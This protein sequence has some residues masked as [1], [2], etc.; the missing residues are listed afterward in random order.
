MQL[1]SL[2][3]LVFL[4]F[5]SRYNL[6][7]IHQVLSTTKEGD[8]L[9]AWLPL[10]GESDYREEVME[11]CW[12]Q[13]R[14]SI[15][16][17]EEN[18]VQAI[19]FYSDYYPA[20]LKEMDDFPPVLYVKGAINWPSHLAAVVGPRDFSSSIPAKTE[21]ITRVLLVQGYGIVSGLALGVDTIAHEQA[22]QQKGYTLAV[23]PGHLNPVY[24]PPNKDLAIRILEGGGTLISELPFG[25]P[26]TQRRFVERNRLTTALSQIVLP[27][28]LREKGGT[29]K[30]IQH[31]LRQRKTLLLTAFTRDPLADN[32]L[33]KLLRKQQKSGN[34][35]VL[36]S[37][38]L[39]ELK[40]QLQQLYDSTPR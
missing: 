5:I 32:S 28:E 29:L 7:R 23:L 39:D 11:K 9:C 1:K 25:I 16:K 2:E 37:H 24:P 36:L 38:H 14:K 4:S 12:E 19:P 31:A 13:T 18:G 33:Q 10:L 21:Q 3:S 35:A 8:D 17:M 15:K 20:A 40:T 27:M 6:S 34:G 30:T 22:L 26:L